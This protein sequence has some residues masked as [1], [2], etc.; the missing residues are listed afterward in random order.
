MACP[1]GGWNVTCE[2]T[3]QLATQ[4]G[5]SVLGVLSQA[6]TSAIAWLATWTAAW[7]LAVPSYTSDTSLRLQG[8]VAPITAMIAVGGVMWQGLLMMVSRRP[9]PVLQVVRILW[10]TA[11]WGAIGVA[12]THL[13]LR[14][15][16]DFSLWILN[17][18]LGQVTE[19]GLTA[20]LAALLVPARAVPPGVI[21][22]VGALVLIAGF[23]QALLMFLREIG[24]VVLA[25][26]LQ[27]AASGAGSQATSQWR[28]RVVAWCAALAAYKPTA[29]VI[30]TVGITMASD[31]D[32]P[33]SF[34]MGV[35][36]LILAI[37]ALPLLV[38][39]FSWT[40]GSLQ[41][42]GGLALLAG[43]GAG[44]VHAAASLRGAGG[45]D[46]HDY[47]RY[48]ETSVAASEPPGAAPPAA[49]SPPT[50]HGPAAGRG[51]PAASSPAAGAS[52]GGA[53][54][55]TGGSGAAGAGGAAAAAATVAQSGISAARSGARRAGREMTDPPTSGG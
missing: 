12:G 47:I 54:G 14:A 28:P 6:I 21:V 37:L 1:A 15:G 31:P 9:E 40:T 53:A 19:D 16:D 42:G 2:V 34:F 23:V 49:S 5:D 8:W 7:W 20:R 44:G 30:Y 51:A 32:D 3:G 13:V 50:F 26:L 52:A 11:L 18:G 45:R 35:T 22:V 46:M 48:L 33:R 55:A 39:L 36:V 43:A 25:G 24:L 4:A 38:R 17:Q 29:A 10:S 41:S 27:L